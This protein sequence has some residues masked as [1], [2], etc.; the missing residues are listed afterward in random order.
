MVKVMQNEFDF[1]LNMVRHAKKYGVSDA[2]RIFGCTR[3]TVRKWR[4]RYLNEGLSGLEDRS[5]LPQNRIN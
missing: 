5:R 4:D 3:K 1:R 2:A